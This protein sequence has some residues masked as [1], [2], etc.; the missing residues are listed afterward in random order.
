MSSTSS[1]KA[2]PA[3]GS[4]AGLST[5]S[6][7]PTRVRNCLLR[8]SLALIRLVLVAQSIG[9]PPSKAL[10]P[11]L[12]SAN[13]HAFHFPAS[14]DVDRQAV[15]D[16]LVPCLTELKGVSAE[17]HSSEDPATEVTGLVVRT[18]E[19]SWSRAARRKVK[20][21]TAAD[22]DMAE[23]LDEFFTC[24]IDLSMATPPGGSPNSSATASTLT[25]ST[26]FLSVSQAA[27]GQSADVAARR[28]AWDGL[29]L[30]LLRKVKDAFL[31][32]PTSSFDDRPD[33][34]KLPKARREVNARAGVLPPSEAA[35]RM[36]IAENPE[37][38]KALAQSLGPDVPVDIRLFQPK[39]FGP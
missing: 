13:S 31:P 28:L 10:L 33:Y 6:S 11:H 21:L 30:H 17:P 14:V 20:Q 26:H 29:W 12:P 24:L 18:T 16:L 5:A 8:C 7:H 1:C 15:L 9:R 2:R 38:L 23:P 25:L 3:A 36:L 32:T 34:L 37:Y 27:A 19:H 39:P 35:K 22:A 4:S